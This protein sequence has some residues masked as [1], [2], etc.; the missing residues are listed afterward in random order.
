MLHQ[1]KR[2]LT[3]DVKSKCEFEDVEVQ[4]KESFVDESS[5]DS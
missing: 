4:G 1:F 2:I 5:K 3:E